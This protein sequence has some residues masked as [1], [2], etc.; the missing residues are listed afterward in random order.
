MIVAW[1]TCPLR[2]PGTIWS[3]QRQCPGVLHKS[4]VPWGQGSWHQG[5]WSQWFWKTFMTLHP[6]THHSLDASYCAGRYHFLFVTYQDNI[7]YLHAKACVELKRGWFAGLGKN[8]SWSKGVK[9]LFLWGLFGFAL[10]TTTLY[11]SD[12]FDPSI[13]PPL[14]ILLLNSF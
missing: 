1:C 8:R 9:Q 4:F 2:H 12:L 13:S 6:I 3:E 7:C 5:A 10:S 11:Y 14:I